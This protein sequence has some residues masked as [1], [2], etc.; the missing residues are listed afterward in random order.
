MHWRQRCVQVV[1]HVFEALVLLAD[2]V[3]NGHAHIFERDVGGAGGPDTGALHLPS[4]D[5]W[6]VLL[7]QHHGD[8][9]H[10]SAASADCNAKVVGKDSVRDPPSEHIR[11][12]CMQ[13]SVSHF[14][15]PFTM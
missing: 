12:A 15:S 5:A 6:H 8:A 2:E 13:R 3:L 9:T 4:G 10:A 11:C 7:D 14:F 1:H